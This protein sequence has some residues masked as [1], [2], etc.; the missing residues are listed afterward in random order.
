M[1]TRQS[2]TTLVLGALAGAGLGAAAL[3]VRR[4]ST[5]GER[6]GDACPTTANS[7]VGRVPSAVP[8]PVRFADGGSAA[9]LATS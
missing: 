7:V 6:C 5:S 4:S 2:L 3:S 1:I 8:V 9:A